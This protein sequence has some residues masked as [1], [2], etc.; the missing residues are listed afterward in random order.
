MVLKGTPTHDVS[1]RVGGTNSGLLVQ[2]ISA[3]KTRT[4]N[5]SG[6]LLK[7]SVSVGWAKSSI[8]TAI[9]YQPTRPVAE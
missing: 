1:T 2:G 5:C 4:R 8:C 3:S 9:A 7:G 6:M